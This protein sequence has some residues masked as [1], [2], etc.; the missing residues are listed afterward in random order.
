[1]DST[2]DG[3]TTEGT[4]N[5][6]SS[7]TKKRGATRMQKIIKQRNAFGKLQI[8]LDRFEPVYGKAGNEFKSYVGLVGRI[9]TPITIKEWSDVP[10]DT[11]A[12]ICKEIMVR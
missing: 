9:N 10:E 7:T 1:M 8:E 2:D 3:G 12:T 6:Q 4:H 11:K 5:T